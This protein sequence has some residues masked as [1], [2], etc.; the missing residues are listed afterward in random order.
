MTDFR[1]FPVLTVLLPEEKSSQ[2][3]TKSQ[4][5]KAG[6]KWAN[7]RKELFLNL[8]FINYLCFKEVRGL[9]AGCLCHTG[10]HS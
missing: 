2:A 6:F 7:L 9:N 5:R 10:L 4:L 1:S 3:G 8:L